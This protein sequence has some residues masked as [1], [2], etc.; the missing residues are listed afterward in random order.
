[1]GS[2]QRWAEYYTFAVSQESENYRLTVGNY[3]R[4]STTRLDLLDIN[5]GKGFTTIDR[6]NDEYAPKN[7]AVNG[8]GLIYLSF[9][10]Q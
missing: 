10:L 9:S 2:E 5:N 8:G 6:E 3:S 1:M 7:C 4:Y